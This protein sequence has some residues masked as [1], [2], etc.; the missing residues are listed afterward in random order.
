MLR[1]KDHQPRVNVVG[2]V[3]P[4]ARQRVNAAEVAG[5]LEVGTHAGVDLG[6]H[7]VRVALELLGTVVAVGV[8]ALVW[9]KEKASPKS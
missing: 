5:L 1:R 7:L 6:A 4:G 2:Y 3:R 8:V 9:W